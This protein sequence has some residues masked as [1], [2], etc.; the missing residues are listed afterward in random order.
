MLRAQDTKGIHD[1]DFHIS[2]DEQVVKMRSFA[3]D[4]RV[5]LHINRRR[6]RALHT[7]Q[8][9]MAVDP[10]ALRTG[11]PLD[12]RREVRNAWGAAQAR[13][14]ELMAKQREHAAGLACLEELQERVKALGAKLA[15]AG[16][17][18][19]GGAQ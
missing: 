2:T 17:A 16:V 7:L 3:E 18:G 10:C 6:D 5:M 12:R 13:I 1:E 8:E 11:L 9:C 19:N 14:G 15:V 4:S